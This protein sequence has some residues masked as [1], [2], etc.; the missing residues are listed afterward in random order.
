MS[1]FKDSKPTL[2]VLCKTLTKKNFSAKLTQ[3]FNSY[4]C[5][6]LAI[7]SQFKFSNV[8]LYCHVLRCYLWNRD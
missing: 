1:L 2:L 5:E 3:V 7:C 4:K 6:I 8:C